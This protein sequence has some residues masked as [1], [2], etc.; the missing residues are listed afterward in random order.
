MSSTKHA[1]PN[2]LQ[3]VIPAIVTPFTEGGGVDHKALA[4]QTAYLS[5]GEVNGFFVAGTTGEG[6][7]LTTDE[8]CEMVKTVRSASGGGRFICIAC[9]RPSTGEVI[10]EMKKLASVKPD[11]IVAVTPFYHSA[12][13][14]DILLHFRTI[15][16]AAPAPLILYNIPSCTHNPVALDTIIALSSERNVAG[17]KDS[18]GDFVQFSRGVLGH[19]REG[20]AW[21]QGEDYLQGP[22][23]L[24]GTKCMVTG[25][26]NVR[27]E[28]YVRMYRAAMAGDWE[29]VRECQ[30]RVN[31][32]YRIVHLC[33]NSTVAAK[34][35]VELAGRGSRALRQASVPVTQQQLDGIRKV[36]KEFDA[37]A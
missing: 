4:K 17:I 15:A 28:P 36:L 19:S 32:L 33:G 31:L 34:A 18:S 12:R 35:A 21:I 6:A 10:A 20:F 24:A 5:G 13:Q 22:A 7:Y 27:V 2:A 30:R 26:S 23:L 8:K 11:Y 16:A 14:E 25:L 37:G 3:G 29:G 1:E 9:I